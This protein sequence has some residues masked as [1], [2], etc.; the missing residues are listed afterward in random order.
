MKGALSYRI[1]MS[2]DSNKSDK[3]RPS[4]GAD[5]SGNNPD[6]SVFDEDNDQAEHNL[7]SSKGNQKPVGNPDTSD[8]TT[9]KQSH[10]NTLPNSLAQQAQR[11]QFLVA[12]DQLGQCL[13]DRRQL[14]TSRQGLI[15][16][17][18]ISWLV[19]ATV[20]FVY[21]ELQNN[22]QDHST[23]SYSSP[24]ITRQTECPPSL[25]SNTQVIQEALARTGGIVR[26]V[27]DDAAN[28][29][30]R[31]NERLQT[32][33]PDIHLAEEMPVQPSSM[34]LDTETRESAERMI[35]LWAIAWELQDVSLYLS[36]YENDFQPESGIAS[37]EWKRQRQE[38]LHKPEWIRIKLEGLQFD[39]YDGETL[40]VSFQQSYR[41]PQYSDITHK[42]LT[43]VQHAGDWKIRQ[44]ITLNE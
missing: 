12:Q 39:N 44:E 36:Y 35:Y 28:T 32:T 21:P 1:A 33:Q 24:T 38:R 11:D 43:L 22:S 9:Q 15:L 17:T 40:K 5:G 18:V 8:N 23:P 16:L 19:T 34:A 6:F 10:D 14:N 31:I 20:I 37:D 7:G 25:S 13:E 2:N 29:L 27:P 3:D 42:Q 4:A 26:D 30:K 41:T